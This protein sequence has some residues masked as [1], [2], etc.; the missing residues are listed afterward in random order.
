[1]GR[2]LFNPLLDADFT[3]TAPPRAP[4]AVHRRFPGYSVT[5][6][7][8]LPGLARRL[9]IAEVRLKDESSRLGLPAYKV[10][11]ASWAV[12]RILADRLGREL[13]PWHDVDQLRARILP[14]LPLTFVTATDGNHGRGVARVARLLGVPARVFVPRGTALA[15]IEAIVG[16]GATVIEVDGTYDETVVAAADEIAE[17][18]VLVQDH[19]WEGYETIP[20]WVAEGYATMFWEIE[21]TLEGEGAP[22]FDLVLVQIGVGTLAAAAIR[23][24]RREGVESRSRVVGVE[25]SGAACTLAAVEAG[26]IVTIPVGPGASIMAGLNCGTVSAA[27]WPTLRAGLDA[28][29]TVDDR[30]AR[31]A[32]RLLADQGLVAG[33]SGAAGVAGLLQLL[34][35]EGGK[36]ARERLGV[37]PR[38]RV[39]VLSTEGATD[40]EAYAKIVSPRR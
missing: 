33:E 6:L 22:P 13:E 15:R 24:F 32:V 14:L 25:P 37:S 11:G 36:A 30:G 16:E 34:E 21:D 29:V 19:G 31:E 28:C 26:R 9:G 18:T 23:H 39:L 10:L 20:A 35:G 8:P 17:R 40:P 2:M 38:S 3:M 7:R 1:M 4:L 5:P 12:T 27:A